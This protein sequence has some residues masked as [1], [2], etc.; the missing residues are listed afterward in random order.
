MLPWR[1]G[2]GLSTRGAVDAVQARHPGVGW[3]LTPPWDF[4]VTG[5]CGFLPTG[6]V[7]GSCFLETPLWEPRRLAQLCCMR[8][9]VPGNRLLCI[10]V[11]W[12]P[13]P[14]WV[15]SQVSVSPK[16]SGFRLQKCLMLLS[17]SP[18]LLVTSVLPTYDQARMMQKMGDSVQNFFLFLKS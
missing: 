6:L 4:S 1:V 10:S 13:W 14:L 2:M 17:P 11:L 8:Q 5:S 16:K 9:W 7:C 18:A 3:G 12:H 15:L